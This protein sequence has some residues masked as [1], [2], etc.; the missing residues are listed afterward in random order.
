MSRPRVPILEHDQKEK[1]IEQI[2]NLMLYTS[3]K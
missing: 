3:F 2:C 1:K